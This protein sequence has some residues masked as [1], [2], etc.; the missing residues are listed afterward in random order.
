MAD[1]FKRLSEFQ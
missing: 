1:T